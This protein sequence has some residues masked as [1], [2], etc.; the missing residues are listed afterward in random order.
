MNFLFDVSNV[1]YRGYYAYP[2]HPCGEI[3]YLF[4]KIRNCLQGSTSHVYLCMD[5]E[6]KGKLLNENYKSNRNHND[7]SVYR[8]LEQAIY[9]LE[10]LD[11]VH[12]KY[13]PELEA[14]E[15]IFSLTRLLDGKKIIVSTDNDLLQS[16]RED[17]EIERKD[18]FITES[19]Y[20][21]EMV[22]KF[23]AVAPERL[24]IYRAIIGDTSDNLKGIVS[25]FPKVLAADIA[26]KIPY[27]GTLPS[28]DVLSEYVEKK[29]EDV[30]EDKANMLNTLL[31]RYEQF[32]VNYTI[33]KL[34]VHTDL[35]FPFLN[36]S[37]ALPSFPD[38]VM[39]IYRTIRFLDVANL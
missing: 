26:M 39:S 34:S 10:D 32:K 6:P 23:Q 7:V 24:P 13:N 27:D 8:Y 29:K 4:S 1:L 5:G 36:S 38:S 22:K 35:N 21:E 30:T 37:I 20:R 16:L 17:V 12:I 15:V 2:K 25:R 33:M 28:K 31:D 3:F 18:M 9:L 19:Y 14:D 11:R